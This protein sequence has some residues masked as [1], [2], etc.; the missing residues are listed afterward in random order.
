VVQKFE[1]LTEPV[2]SPSSGT[3]LPDYSLHERLSKLGNEGWEMCGTVDVYGKQY[4]V[5]K[6]PES[7]E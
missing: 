7:D 1:Y 3:L 2:P 4:L 5:F 6:R